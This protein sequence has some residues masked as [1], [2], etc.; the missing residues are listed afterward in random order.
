M[1]SFDALP[2]PSIRFSY[3]SDKDPAWRRAFIR[4][5]ERFTGQPYLR[6]SYFDWVSRGVTG[7]TIFAAGLR[8]LDMPLDLNGEALKNV[9]AT[10]PLLVVA[11]ACLLAL[12]R[13]PEIP[14]GAIAVCQY[15]LS[16]R[17]D[18]DGERLY[19]GMGQLQS[20]RVVA[21]GANRLTVSVD[22]ARKYE[23]RFGDVLFNR[24]NSLELVGKTGIVRI[25]MAFQ[26]RPMSAWVWAM[27]AS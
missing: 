1:L 20:G 27:K 14:L 11:R 13:T 17:S 26:M 5:I 7:E 18:P 10:G 16:E 3:A 6:R 19:I 25:V 21:A 8:L 2:D 15:G 4:I 12:R 22:V 24:T 23:L 9:P